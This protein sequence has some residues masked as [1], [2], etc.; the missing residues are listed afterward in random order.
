M[1]PRGTILYSASRQKTSFCVCSTLTHDIIDV[2]ALCSALGYATS[3]AGDKHSF[4]FQVQ[5]SSTIIFKK[6]F[7]LFA[8]ME[9]TIFTI[10]FTMQQAGQAGGCTSLMSA[11][12]PD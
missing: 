12:N 5:V 8:K 3:S 1:Q 9:S 10:N 7:Y 2:S 4:L 6:I 11:L